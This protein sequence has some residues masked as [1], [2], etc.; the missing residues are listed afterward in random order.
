MPTPAVRATASRLASAPPALNT[1]FAASSTRSRFRTASVRG[2]RAVLR[3]SLMP[4]VNFDPLISPLSPLKSGSLRICR[5]GARLNH[6]IGVKP[7]RQSPEKR[8]TGRANL[9]KHDP[10][11]WDPVFGKDHAQAKSGALGACVSVAPEPTKAQASAGRRAF[12]T[13]R[14]C[15]ALHGFLN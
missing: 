2:F 8:L 5:N 7:C 15:G 3:A 9:L 6:S 1:A 13:H 4:A 14:S 11:K 12:L 10:E